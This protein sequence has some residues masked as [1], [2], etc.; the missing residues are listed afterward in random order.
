MKLFVSFRLHT[1]KLPPTGVLQSFWPYD[2]KT[3]LEIFSKLGHPKK[4][5]IRADK[6]IFDGIFFRGVN[7]GKMG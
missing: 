3:G 1:L 5:G 2:S 4:G 7:E 6:G